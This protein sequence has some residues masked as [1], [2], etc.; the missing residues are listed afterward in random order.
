[1][2]LLNQPGVQTG[3]SGAGASAGGISPVT[4]QRVHQQR[5][6]WGAVQLLGGN[7]IHGGAAAVRWAV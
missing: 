5:W 7:D 2:K 6:E 3:S 1:V 4:G